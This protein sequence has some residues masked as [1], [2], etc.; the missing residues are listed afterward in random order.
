MISKIKAKKRI[1]DLKSNFRR[2]LN[3]GDTVELI[4]NYKEFRNWT[5]EDFDR[6]MDRLIEY[7]NYPENLV[8]AMKEI[9]GSNSKKVNFLRDCYKCNN[10]GYRYYKTDIPK[11]GY[12][13]NKQRFITA[14]RVCT[15]ACG[16]DHGKLKHNREGVPWFNDIIKRPGVEEVADSKQERINEI[17]EPLEDNH[18]ELP[19]II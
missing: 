7:D 16:C 8:T 4:C 18:E 9:Y 2:A 19:F 15:A 17:L 13:F 5:D 1:S 6:V 3:I 14:S 12:N 11:G 10:T